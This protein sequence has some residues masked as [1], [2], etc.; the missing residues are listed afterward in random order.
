M[1]KRGAPAELDA[2]K[3]VKIDCMIL[4]HKSQPLPVPAIT[5][6]GVTCI[7]INSADSWLNKIVGDR[8]MGRHTIGGEGTRRRD[9]SR[10]GSTEAYFHGDRGVILGC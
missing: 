6:C 2:I 9:L 1:P 4:A 5:E 10:D 8:C 7:T 3:V